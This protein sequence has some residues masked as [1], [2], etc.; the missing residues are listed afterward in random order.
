MPGYRRQSREYSGKQTRRD[1]NYLA[2]VGE[3]DAVVEEEV[4]PLLASAVILIVLH[5]CTFAGEA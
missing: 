5:D 3:H 2:D 4:S 1:P